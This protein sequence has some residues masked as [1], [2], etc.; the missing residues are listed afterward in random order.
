MD[1]ELDKKPV[2]KKVKPETLAEACMKA[3]EEIK[4]E[5]IIK[6]KLGDLTII[7]DYFVICSGNSTPQIKAIAS[8]VSRDI[9]EKYGIHVRS[10]DGAPESEWIV[11]D[12]GS[13][14]VHVMS[15]K[16]R[17]HYQMENL[18]G[19]APKSG[20]RPERKPRKKA[21]KTTKTT[22]TAKKKTTPD[23]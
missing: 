2:R 9:R 14:I 12:F 21:V 17:D 5:D 19:D 1:S 13:V 22:K 10:H 15:K 8:R 16:T 18:W 23:L 11:L 6:L 4:A 3:A 7:A 20:M